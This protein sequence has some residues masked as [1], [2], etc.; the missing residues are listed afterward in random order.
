MLRATCSVC[1][2]GGDVLRIASDLSG[3]G[4]RSLVGWVFVCAS[5]VFTAN[6]LDRDDHG[7]VHNPRMGPVICDDCTTARRTQLEPI[8]DGLRARYSDAL[9]HELEEAEGRWADDRA[10]ITPA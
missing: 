1:G 6:R 2:V 9:A 7:T 8:L 5:G 10:G 3:N 4:G